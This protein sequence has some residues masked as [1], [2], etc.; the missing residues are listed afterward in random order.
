MTS[1]SSK[2]NVVDF[3]SLCRKRLQH[4]SAFAREVL[5]SS[6]EMMKAWYDRKAVE[7]QFQPGDK[8][9]V[10]F[11]VSGSALSARFTGPYVVKSKVLDTDYIIQT[12]E[13]KRKNR[14]CH[15]NMLKLY[16]YRETEGR[17]QEKTLVATIL[18][19]PNPNPSHQCFET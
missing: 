15:I 7:T 13:R 10:L 3:V 19:N 2:T 11:P 4:T 12:P 8:V 16:H 5:S 6:Q 14:L 17:E 1:P 18:D 9:L